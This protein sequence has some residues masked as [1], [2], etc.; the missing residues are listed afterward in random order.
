M[1]QILEAD[2]DTI[3]R[4]A[5]R[6]STLTFATSTGLRRRLFDLVRTSELDGP[7]VEVGCYTGGTSIFLA[8]ACAL[9][10]RELILVDVSDEFL[11]RAV[12]NIKQ[13][14]GP[15][16]VIPFKGTSRQ[17]ATSNMLTKRPLLAFIDADHRYGAVLED[18]CAM[19]SLENE[20]VYWAFHDYSLRGT[21]GDRT[22]IAV[23]RA[24]HDQFGKID[25]MERIGTQTLA[26]TAPNHGGDFWAANGSEGILFKNS[27]AERKPTATPAQA[28]ANH[29]TDL[30]PWPEWLAD[31]FR[32]VD[33]RIKDLMGR[34]LDCEGQTQAFVKRW[35]ADAVP[36]IRRL[37]EIL[38]SETLRDA[39]FQDFQSMI[40]GLGEGVKS[41]VFSTKACFP[42]QSILNDKLLNILGLCALR[43]QFVRK[44]IEKKRRDAISE[45][46]RAGNLSP[47]DFQETD[48]LFANLD[49]FEEN[50]FLAL[51]VGSERSYE[52]ICQ[53]LS[54]EVVMKDQWLTKVDGDTLLYRMP[55]NSKD[56]PEAMSV[57]RNKD[58]MLSY[59]LICGHEIRPIP[60]YSEFVHQGGGDENEDDANKIWHMDTFHNTYKWWCFFSGVKKELGPFMYFPGS[61]KLDWKKMLWLSIY[62][63]YTAFAKERGEVVISPRISSADL[64]FFGLSEPKAFDVPPMTL[65]IADTFGIHR[66]SEPEVSGLIRRSFFGWARSELT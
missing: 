45:L 12:S 55:L 36:S 33:Q 61:N 50:G 16:T 57:V 21:M 5:E 66:R 52:T 6:A 34:A 60:V 25:P 32:T 54:D 23:D 1:A 44:S 39:Y 47:K 7:V 8:Q 65:V 51:S 42:A 56:T 20:P 14:V 4:K 38:A 41:V 59:S 53:E 27:D 15:C 46:M 11:Q 43:A 63:T 9:T 49:T 26:E 18:I 58:F 40:D 35:Y 62:S 28:K 24:V 3:A 13:I 30:A 29:A 48:Q 31:D 37:R 17:F 19:A 2:F 10:G 22:Q 64:E